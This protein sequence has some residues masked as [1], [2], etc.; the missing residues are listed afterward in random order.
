MTDESDDEAVITFGT[1]LTEPVPAPETDAVVD[2]WW[3]ET[4]CNTGLDAESLNR[5]R[6][7]ADRLKILLAAARR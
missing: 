4:F 1:E 7:A 6:A 3:A 5:Y 2:G